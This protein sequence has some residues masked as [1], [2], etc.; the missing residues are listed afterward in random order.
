MTKAI[1]WWKKRWI[2]LLIGFAGLLVV[3]YLHH[4]DVV[5]RVSDEHITAL[6]DAKLQPAK[7]EI[8]DNTDKKVGPSV[9]NWMV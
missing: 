1:P 8:S 6:I 2:E 4:L 3:W 7:A 5:A 9:A